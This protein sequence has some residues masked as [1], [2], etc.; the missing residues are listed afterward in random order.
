VP[1]PFVRDLCGYREG[2]PNTSD[3]GDKGSILLGRLLFERLG[4]VATTPPPDT[5]VDEAMTR[6]LIGDLR[7]A[8]PP[9][10]SI[11][12]NGHLSDFEQFAHLS[13]MKHLSKG[14]G[15]KQV[16]RSF[17]RLERFVTS[18]ITLPNRDSVKLAELI[19]G[20]RKAVQVQAAERTQLIEQIGEES[21]L[22]LDVVA[23]RPGSVTKPHLL[24]GLSLKWTLRT[25]RAQDCRSQ[26]AKMAA[27]RRGR[28]PHFATV[29]MEPRPSMLALLG[30]GSGDLDCVYHLDLAALTDAVQDYYQLSKR[31]RQRPYDTFRQLVE[32]RR[33]RDYDELARS[34]A[35]L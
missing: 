22:R 13:A 23:Y 3:A 6:L 20:H 33:L 19:A 30:R 4:V 21:L 34:I 12:P 24:T 25:D 8:A 7:D 16:Q 10:L 29:T 18:R 15:D 1:A 26:G 31:H 27:L 9:G 32:Q 35:D 14:D 5:K 28:M 2:R 17:E 11:E